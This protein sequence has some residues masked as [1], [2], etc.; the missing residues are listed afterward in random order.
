MAA[1]G[2]SRRI[3]CRRHA[4]GHTAAP[5]RPAIA[6]APC[7]TCP[8]GRAGPGG[9]HVS[10]GAQPAPTRLP[11]LRLNAEPSAFVALAGKGGDLGTR[12]AAL[13][14]RVEWPGKPG[15]VA[16]TPLTPAE[17]QR[18]T[19]GQEVYRNVC[20]ACH[21]PDGRGMD[22]IAPTLVGSAFALAN[23][24]V[25][26]RILLHG[27]EG[28]VGMMP[29]VGQTFT[30]DQGSRRCS[31]TSGVSGPRAHLRCGDRRGGAS[32]DRDPDTP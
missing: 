8:G 1:N 4:A 2:D 28:T 3:R 15:T 10:A 20:Q 31:P 24:D 23:P 22:K 16:V 11:P 7:P 32:G 26:V 27:K 25:P 18:F 5:W 12:A 17:Q 14:A 9:A 13:I 30:D 19:A 29:P 21:Q 6:S